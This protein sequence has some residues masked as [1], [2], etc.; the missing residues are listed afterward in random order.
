MEQKVIDTDNEASVNIHVIQSFQQKVLFISKK[1]L[2]KS[3]NK[4]LLL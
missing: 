3:K 4:T 2:K 1:T